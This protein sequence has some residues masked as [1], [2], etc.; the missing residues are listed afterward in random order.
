MNNKNKLNE[1]NTSSENRNTKEKDLPSLPHTFSN[2]NN[3]NS[4]SNQNRKL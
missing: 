4:N 3:F 2:A 1:I